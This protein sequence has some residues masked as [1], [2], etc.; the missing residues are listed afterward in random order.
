MLKELIQEIM[1]NSMTS[2]GQ[3]AES[4]GIQMETL[5]D[6]LKILVDKGMLRISECERVE[7]TKCASCPIAESS[8]RGDIL[9]QAYY[10]TERGK[11]YAS[12]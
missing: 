6:L 10:V 7:Q 12:K 5:E 9:G 1:H 2:K 11:R 3:I 4:L 8:C